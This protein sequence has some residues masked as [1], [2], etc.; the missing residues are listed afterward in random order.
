MEASATTPLSRRACLWARISDPD[1][2]PRRWWFPPSSRRDDVLRMSEAARQAYQLVVQQAHEQFSE[3]VRLA[4]LSLLG[5]ALFCLLIT[6][7]TPD[8][9]LLVADPTIKMPFADVQVSFHSFLI[10]APFLL[11]II[12]LYL[13]IFYGYWLDFE[14]DYQHL[15]PS[16]ESRKPPMRRLPTLFSLGHPVPRLLTALI[17][18]W[19]V[20]LVLLVMTWKAAARVEWGLPLTLLTGLVTVALV[21]LRIRRRPASQR[22]WNRPLWGVMGLTAGGMAALAVLCMAQLPRY[23]AIGEEGLVLPGFPRPL[24]IVRADLQGKW[25]AG[26]DL[27]DASATLATLQGATLQGANLAGANLRGTD[28]RAANLLG[29]EL[30]LANLEGAD[31]QHAELSEP[32]FLTQR[33]FFLVDAPGAEWLLGRNFLSTTEPLLHAERLLFRNSPIGLFADLREANLQ[34]ANLQGA[35]LQG[36]NLE[37]ANLQKVEGLTEEQIQSARIDENTK[38]PP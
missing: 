14:T 17:F 22:R 23:R 30:L 29:A 38:L 10:L 19:L 9:A 28:L 7:G 11:I 13:H 5:F 20:P 21:F 34:G 37:G 36:A 35:N 26:A 31:L 4:M 25:L 2:P 8:S 6:L 33:L 32:R 12:T 3:T 1:K 15:T 16:R 27:R 24:N 18:Y